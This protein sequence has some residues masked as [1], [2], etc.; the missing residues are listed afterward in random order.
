VCVNLIDAH[1]GLGGQEYRGWKPLSIKQIARRDVVA[2]L[3]H[4]H[5]Q[6][7]GWLLLEGVLDCH[8]D[9]LCVAEGP[10]HVRTGQKAQ[11][12]LP[13][14]TAPVLEARRL[15]GVL[16]VTEPLTDRYLLVSISLCISVISV[17]MVDA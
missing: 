14:P 2:P 15:Q 8:D 3:R 7:Y 9:R 16:D 11:F 13:P 4:D 1:Q 10:I 17:S 6:H 12:G 5:Q